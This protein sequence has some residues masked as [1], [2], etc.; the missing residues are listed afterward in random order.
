MTLTVEDDFREF[1]AA[2]WPDLE[3]VALLVTLDA[4]AARRITT[5]ALARLHQRWRA[6][7]D[8]GRPGELA[9]RAVLTAA[10]SA[11]RD[12]AAAS[13]PPSPSPG[14]APAASWDDPDDDDVAD[15]VVAA[16]A[17]AL[18][19]A[20]PVQRAVLAGRAVWDLEPDEVAALLGMP[21]AAVRAEV[22]ALRDR[23]AR[24]HDEARREEGLSP[25]PWALDPDVDD[26][27]AMLLRGQG[28]PPDPAALV[29]DRSR[30]VRRRTLVVGGLGVLGAAAGA[31]AVGTGLTSGPSAST[32]ARPVL[33]P[34]GDRS[35][36]GTG[37]W[38][39][40]GALAGDDGIQAL[41]ISRS[42]PGSRLL[43]ADEVGDRRIVVVRLPE[44]TRDSTV[45]SV[46]A[47]PRGA[48]APALTEVPLTVREIDRT[49]NVVPVVVPDGTGATGLLVVL[50]R[51]GE[52]RCSYSATVVFTADGAVRRRWTEVGLADGVGASLV[53]LPV[54]PAVRVRAGRF[55]GAPAGP[56]QVTL[57]SGSG[58]EVGNTLMAAAAPFAMAVT[59]PPRPG[60]LSL[61]AFEG[62]APGDVIDPGAVVAQPR[63]G[64]VAVVHTTTPEG[65]L[66]RSVRVRDD[67]RGWTPYLDLETVR[68]IA[69]QD[70]DLPF[71]APLPPVREDTGRFLV[72]A[73]GAARAQLLAVTPNAYPVSRVGDLR[74]GTGVLEVANARQAAIYR[75][76]L[77]DDR[78]ARLGSWR[79]AFGRRDPD[80]LW[81]R[82]AA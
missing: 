8:E 36:A 5:D 24:A 56:Q 30:A 33:P 67:G 54:G 22:A 17:T 63:E 9:R 14:P 78:G 7:V 69:V 43:W 32:A 35:W 66:L 11:T 21:S 34:P 64:R 71:A 55:D 65:A 45:V 48:D 60:F 12:T 62:P 52:E 15:P 37:T 41:V 20:T 77:W 72:V 10:T 75:L 50:A 57:G 53:P 29:A 19:G 49:D 2:R 47:G 40:R 81:P 23:L 76:V 38:T 51:P 3:A 46:W 42:G 6:T 31:W 28:D 25:A 74:R 18:H 13:S 80:D 27:V 61:L 59:G 73:P 26:A 68:P 16:L 1:V 79:Q 58:G 82:F 70:A 44:S 39:P 4:P